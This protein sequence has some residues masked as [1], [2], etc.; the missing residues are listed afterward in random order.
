[1]SRIEIDFPSPAIFST[2]I[3]IR[4]TDL[5][6]GAHLGND[7][8]LSLLHEARMRLLISLGYS[9]KNIE[10]IGIIMA[11]VAIMYKSESFYGDNLL[12]EIAAEDFTRVAFD[13]F[14]KVTCNQKLVAIAKTGIVCFNYSDKKV[15][16]VPEVFVKKINDLKSGK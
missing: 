14:Y 10:G 15:V 7:T 5:N 16:S 12:I 8:L 3:Q 6:Y 11:D 2:S 9:E 13:I 4:I 1:M